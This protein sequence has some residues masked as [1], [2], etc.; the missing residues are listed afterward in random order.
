MD[1]S[2]GNKYQ[3]AVL[4]IYSPS[5]K[6]N[7]FTNMTSVEYSAKFCQKPVLA[8]VWQNIPLIEYSSAL[9]TAYRSA[10][11]LARLNPRV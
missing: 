4:A 9:C 6:I 11:Q 1:T 10:G 7:S 8:E 3:H 5:M 2:N